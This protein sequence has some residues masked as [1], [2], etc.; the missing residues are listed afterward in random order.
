MTIKH[1]VKKYYGGLRRLS[2]KNKKQKKETSQIERVTNG[3]VLDRPLQKLEGLRHDV[4][5][6]NDIQI[7]ELK[8]HVHDFLSWLDAFV[9]EY[10]HEAHIP[11]YGLVS[12]FGKD[13]HR[14]ASCAK[15]KGILQVKSSL[16]KDR[17][18]HMDSSI[19]SISFIE[20]KKNESKE[21]EKENE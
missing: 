10:P 21:G 4:Y 1:T 8:K 18:L 5:T 13:V 7:D 9:V 6:M 16:L 12:K 2:P 14:L 19:S 3:I 15:G 11:F 17:S 20:D